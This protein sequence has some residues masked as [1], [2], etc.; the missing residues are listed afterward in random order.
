MDI[1]DFRTH[2][3]LPNPHTY[4]VIEHLI[5]VWDGRTAEA[6]AEM[7]YY[8]NL[9]PDI[10]RFR[11]NFKICLKHIKNCGKCRKLHWNERSHVWLPDFKV[12]NPFYPD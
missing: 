9:I 11:Y 8:M 7:A 2:L 6:I 4:P 3:I 5:D 1:N 10:N 12:Y